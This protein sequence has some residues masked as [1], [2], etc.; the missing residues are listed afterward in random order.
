MVLLCESKSVHL[1][2]RLF[3]SVFPVEDQ[4][5]K[6]GGYGPVNRFNPTT[7]CVPVSSQDMYFQ[8]RMKCC[9]FMFIGVR[10]EVIIPFVDFGGIVDH[11]CLYFLFKIDRMITLPWLLSCAL[12]PWPNKNRLL[13]VYTYLYMAPGF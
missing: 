12:F 7:C 10:S 13:D 11:H 4:I 8:H 1:V 5:I 6:R 2:Y 3:I 9:L